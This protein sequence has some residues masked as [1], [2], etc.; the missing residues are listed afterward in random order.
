MDIMTKC[1]ARLF[2]VSEKNVTLEMRK[3]AKA[4]LYMLFYGSPMS[5]IS[6]KN[7]LKLFLKKST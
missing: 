3:Q 1:A 2:G 5:D 6:V 7:K 4:A